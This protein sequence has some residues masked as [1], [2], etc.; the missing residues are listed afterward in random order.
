MA[1]S[2]VALPREA[3]SLL[4]LKYDLLENLECAETLEEVATVS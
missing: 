1:A 3:K 4:N 2:Y